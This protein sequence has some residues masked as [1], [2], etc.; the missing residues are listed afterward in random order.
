MKRI[1]FHKT[2]KAT[3]P[4]VLPVIH[5]LSVEQTERN[6]RLA[7]GEG[8]PGIFLINH[9]FPHQQFLP[10]IADI[11]AKFPN[12]W[13]G[14]NFLG[15]NGKIAFP[16]L[17]QLSHEGTKIDAY[18][19]DDACVD[20]RVTEQKRA[21]E[22][23]EVRKNSGW[24]GMYFGGT[25]FKKQRS[26]ADED[27]ESSAKAAIALMDVVTTSGAA[28]GQAASVEKV[29][30]MRR[31][32]GESTLALASGVTPENAP[33]YIEDVDCFIVATGISKP[34]N[35][36]NFDPCRLRALMRVTRNANAAP[37]DERV[38]EKW[39]L[40]LMKPNTKGPNF[41]WLDP[42]SMYMDGAAFRE[43]S[44]DL[45]KPFHPRDIDIV[46]GIDGMGF[47]LGSAIATKLG[48]G[49]LAI[50]KAGHLCVDTEEHAYVDYSNRE[51]RMELRK[52]AFPANTRVLIVDQWVE[53]GGTMQAAISLIEKQAG[54]VAGV[55]A[56]CMEQN[57]PLAN[58]IRQKYKC[59]FAV[60]E[61]LQ[62]KFDEHRFFDSSWG[63]I[64]SSPCS[65]RRPLHTC[66]IWHSS[67]FLCN[68]F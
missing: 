46:A 65:N 62:K 19:A 58:E 26:V 18:W 24:D 25:A 43:L 42:S 10:I 16:I 17:A 6:I 45:M 15:V 27:L 29:K 64:Y 1:E 5:V 34:G 38:A 33:S 12:L 54:V 52:N 60:P 2:F 40:G 37:Q 68:N 30:A 7:V 66:E 14:V 63:A 11:R 31:G 41:A 48:K 57:T 53:T 13:L 39:Y 50:R 32:C 44:E 3:G 8:V 36:Y 4:V 56:I 9:D 61:H 67:Q 22:I 47:P 49:F 21:M 35:F 23:L 55:V 59:S 51:K 28:T 20:E